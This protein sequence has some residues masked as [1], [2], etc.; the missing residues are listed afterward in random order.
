MSDSIDRLRDS[1]PLQLRSTNQCP[2]LG[3]VPPG[4][5]KLRKTLTSNRHG[6]SDSEDQEYQSDD[7]LFV[8]DQSVATKYVKKVSVKSRKSEPVQTREDEYDDDPG[9][10]ESQ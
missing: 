6:A 1:A 8:E 9:R 5:N 2:A 3:V 7:G 4:K 10:V